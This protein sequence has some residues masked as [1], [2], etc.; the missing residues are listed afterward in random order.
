LNRARKR[1]AVLICG[2]ALA[3]SAASVPGAIA[4]A[5]PARTDESEH[6]TPIR[7]DPP[8]D[9]PKEEVLPEDVVCYSWWANDEKAG[10]SC[11]EWGGDDQYVRDTLN[12]EANFRVHVKTS[13][14]KERWCYSTSS[15]WRSCNFDHKENSYV[16][17][18]GYH[19]PHFL[20]D[21]LWTEWHSA[22]NGS[23]KDES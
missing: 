9:L 18:H 14:G 4:S 2:L 13:Y 20:G 10:E 21:E 6:L 16:K 7:I 11:F 15:Y 12:N 17:W 8:K 23:E 5:A 19:P 1:V 3:A 22:K